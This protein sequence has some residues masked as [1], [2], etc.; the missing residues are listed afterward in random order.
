MSAP[1]PNLDQIEGVLDAILG[2]KFNELFGGDL[3]LVEKVE[4]KLGSVLDR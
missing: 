3:P 2:P 1:P 4:L